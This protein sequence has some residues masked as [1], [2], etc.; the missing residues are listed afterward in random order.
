MNLIKFEYDDTSRKYQELWILRMRFFLM[1]NKCTEGNLWLI[2]VP[3]KRYNTRSEYLYSVFFCPEKH[4]L[5]LCQL[6]IICHV[7]D[8][9]TKLYI[10]AVRLNIF[11][12]MM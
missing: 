12:I 10:T 5:V 7:V 4:R 6:V 8:C 2:E 1:K 3:E 9:S 11:E